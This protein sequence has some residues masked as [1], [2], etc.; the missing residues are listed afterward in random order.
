MYQFSSYATCRGLTYHY[1]SCARTSR[2]RPALN[3]A[4]ACCVGA[5]VAVFLND[6]TNFRTETEYEDALIIKTFCFQ[7]FNS[8]TAL[9]YIAFVKSLGP[10]LF[11]ANNYEDPDVSLHRRPL[12]GHSLTF[13]RLP[14]SV[15]AKCV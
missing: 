14:L 13:E 2:E 7:F 3:R 4:R 9:F 6:F 8:Y 1:L 11:N 15:T 5:Q 12:K 10:S